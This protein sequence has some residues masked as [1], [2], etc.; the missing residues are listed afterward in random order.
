MSIK[1]ELEKIGLTSDNSVVIGSGILS[2]LNIRESKDIDIVVDE[3]IYERLSGDSRFNKS[4][5]HGREILTDKLLEIGTSW[6]VLDKNWKFEDFLSKSAAI[7]GVRYITLE[8]L[9]AVKKSWLLDKDVRQKDIDDVELIENYLKSNK[10]YYKCM[11]CG[12]RYTDKETA[13][14]CRA[15]C[16]EHKSCNLDIIKHAIKETP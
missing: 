10:K 6:G 2:A 15:W 5:N 9:L 1:D 11:E 13:E 4:E 7:D 8:F 12:L 14:K 16:S 3:K